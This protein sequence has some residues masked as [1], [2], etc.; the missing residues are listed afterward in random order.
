MSTAT[1]SQPRHRTSPSDSLDVPKTKHGSEMAGPYI[2][3]KTLGRGTSGK[4]KVAYH[5]DSGLEV[6]VKIIK[7][8][9][10]RAHKQKIAREIAVM[11][12]LEHP[13]IIK[14][15]D[16][17]ETRQHYFMVM[18][19]V[20]GGELFD[21]ILQKGRLP[22]KEALRILSQ[23]VQGLEFCHMHSICH[24]D[25][26]PENLLLDENCNIKMA[27][28]GMAQI[29]P[30]GG[31]LGT[32]CGSPHYGAPEVV[33]GIK[34]DGRKSDVWSLGVVF[35]ALVTGMLP[36]DHKNIPD[37][38]RLVKKGNYTIPT[39]VDPDIQDLLR[40]MLCVD[41]NKRMRTPE[42]KFHPVFYG[43][44]GVN[45][46]FPANPQ[47]SP[48]LEMMKTNPIEEREQID[49]TILEDLEGLGWGTKNELEERLLLKRG[50]S[51]HNLEYVFYQLLAAR[52]K[53]REKENRQY[54]FDPEDSLE[55]DSD[56]VSFRPPPPSP[57]SARATSHGANTLSVPGDHD[58]HHQQQHASSDD[59]QGVTTTTIERKVVDEVKR[60][61]T[62]SPTA[63]TDQQKKTRK[64]LTVV[65]DQKT[66]SSPSQS[67]DATVTPRFHRLK[68]VTDANEP[69]TPT[70]PVTPTAKRSWF[71]SLFRRRPSV[72]IVSKDHQ[73]KGA[74][75]M[76]SEMKPDDIRRE[77]QRVLSDMGVSIKISSTSD[78]ELK[79][80]AMCYLDEQFRI[81]ITDKTG[82]EIK[83]QDD[84][85]DDGDQPAAVRVHTQTQ[86]Q[87]PSPTSPT[88]PTASAS[89]NNNTAK[90][91][92][93]KP[94]LIKFSVDISREP[95]DKVSC[96]NF[97][98]R[99]GNLLVYRGLYTEIIKKL[100]L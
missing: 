7:K 99:L 59:H 67:G 21:Y 56:P 79:C 60:A 16:V 25:L 19:R 71:K 18:E 64:P 20:K 100:T 9:Y 77:V 84:S 38:L 10:V 68:L 1:Q 13:H 95:T 32:F 93:S 3:G 81:V 54:K 86:A 57:T 37:L 14:L 74:S 26:K 66:T 85:K 8:D 55:I 29:I 27:D 90:I 65:V 49:Q 75:G 23:I 88:S 15:Y 62:D 40:K 52:N 12:L 76:Y 11:R 94:Q 48:A 35:Y 44:N 24:R 46:Y 4:V 63:T 58:H 51:L 34:Y 6:A 69:E 73:Q 96:V 80:E 91:D 30:D 83:Y 33:S 98:H 47:P 17:F 5:K 92:P 61:E 87:P 89:T 39:W 41:V 42:I 50:D 53:A 36:F 82:Q 70:S 22:R 28:F 31:V 43:K 97:N 45:L 2:L 78:Y 72:D